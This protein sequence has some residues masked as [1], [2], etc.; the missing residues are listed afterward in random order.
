[1]NEEGSPDVGVGG[2]AGPRWDRWAAGEEDLTGHTAE[3]P[4][5]LKLDV[6]G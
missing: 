6:A 1:M 3:P 4:A 5:V 2:T